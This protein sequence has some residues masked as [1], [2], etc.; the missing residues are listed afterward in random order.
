MKKLAEY[1]LVGYLLVGGII[2]SF[3]PFQGLRLFLSSE[4]YSPVM[5]RFVGTFLLALAVFVIN[6]L[7]RKDPHLLSTALLARTVILTGM[8]VLYFSSRN[9]LFLVLTGIVGLG[10]ILSLIA[11][12]STESRE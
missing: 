4:V 11:L 6:G 3:L 9:P 10:Y 12:F 1:Y 2:F 8:V 5:V 7:I